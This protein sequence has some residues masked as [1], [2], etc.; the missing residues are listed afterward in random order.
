[1]SGPGI[2]EIEVEVLTAKPRV[3]LVPRSHLSMELGHLYMED[4]VRGP[5][6][7]RRHFATI[8]PWADF[9]LS[10]YGS[11]H[12]I[13]TCFLVDDY[14][15]TITTPKELVPELLEAAAAEGL[16][17][18][19]LARESGC[20]AVGPVSP[21]A[22]VMARVVP[23][24]PQGTSG[25]RPP[26]HETGWLTNSE[27]MVRAGGVDEAMAGF[28]NWEPPRENGA[29][30]HSI[31]MDVQLWDNEDGSRTW[32]CAFLSAVWQ[33]MRLGL[34]RHEGKAI[35]TPGP[36]AAE[37]PDHWDDL[38]SVIR[39]NE[40]AHPFCAFRTMTV[41]ET[42]FAGV[43][44]AVRMILS[45]VVVDP[46]VSAQVVEQ[47]KAQRIDLPNDLVR[48]VSHVFSDGV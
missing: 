41:L 38:P 46:I 18:D 24:P 34:L 27:G 45:Q 13:S 36:W 29:Q 11:P 6:S 15:S 20:A 23:D 30:S 14:F 33:L 31:C 5:E 47:A 44:A 12:R 8:K 43:E 1:V 3:E 7:L 35:V 22:L 21:A 32:S 48:R 4:L 16:S 28:R 42:R 10:R 9:V 19:Y 40:R 26:A 39:L 17:I 25:L 37:Y 2:P